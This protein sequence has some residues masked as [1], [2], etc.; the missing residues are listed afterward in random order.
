MIVMQE[1]PKQRPEG[2]TRKNQHFFPENEDIY[3]NDLFFLMKRFYEKLLKYASEYTNFKTFG[4]KRTRLISGVS[5]YCNLV[6]LVK[7]IIKLHGYLI[8]TP[9]NGS[10]HTRM[11]IRV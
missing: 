8:Q 5:V 11:I 10:I 6:H 4:N 3:Y 9:R 1:K 7:I 2:D